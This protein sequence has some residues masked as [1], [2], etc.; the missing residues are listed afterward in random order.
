MTSYDA[1]KELDPITRIIQVNPPIYSIIAEGGAAGSG[2]DVVSEG[3]GYGVM[4]A[5]ITLAAMESNDPYRSDTMTRFEGY[6]NGWKRMCINSTPKSFCQDKKLCGGG[7]YACL[8]GWKHDG[9][10]TEV[11][12][13]GAAPDGD[14]DAIMGMILAVKAV[15]NDTIKPAWYD[16]VRVWADASS[17]SFIYHNTKPSKTGSSARIV[18]LG[19]CWG[20]W[21]TEGNNP[22][23]H[24]PGSYRLMKTYQE[25]FVSGDR[26]YAMPMFDDGKSMSERWDLVIDTSY[27]FLEAAKC[28]DMG[29]VPNWAMATETSSG[30]I[31]V[32][33]GSFSGSGTPQYEFGSEASRT[34]W[35]VLI[36]VILFPAAAYDDVDAFLRPLHDRLVGG[37]S[38]SSGGW[39]SNTLSTCTGVNAVFPNWRYNS[40][41]YSPVYSTLALKIYSGVSTDEQQKMVDDAGALVNNIPGGLSYYSRCWSIIGI[42]TLNGD[43][44]KANGNDTTDAPTQSPMKSP[45]T[46]ASPTY[47]PS[48]SPTSTRTKAP[49][50]GDCKSWC[51]D[52]NASWTKKCS[53]VN[54]S[55]CE[56]CQITDAPTVSPTD[57]NVDDVLSDSPTDKATDEPTVSPTV[58]TTEEPTDLD[59]DDEDDQKD[60]DGGVTLDDELLTSLI[61][62]VAVLNELVDA[63]NALLALLG[64]SFRMSHF[65]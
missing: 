57:Q 7:S 19:S 39:S 54:C 37:Y 20:G 56:E 22:S 51:A 58:K 49:T 42:L 41:I 14:Q 26:N 11:I 53:W 48:K 29:L 44:A 47:S 25:E 9:D 2:G 23:Y 10:L 45:P 30:N 34:M 27:K 40:F 32:Y 24:S 17:T 55:L 5:G 15:E 38:Q 63:L 31:E 64:T 6:F 12:G 35:R 61:D 65:G 59:F 8:P 36:D 18:K 21:E 43:V 60:D 33:P 50:S 52:S 16:E 28:D 13:T 1:L 3:Q 46:S 62:L 4:I